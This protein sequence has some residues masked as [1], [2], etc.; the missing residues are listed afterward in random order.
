MRGKPKASPHV[1][2]D[3]EKR[4]KPIV[5]ID[6]AFLGPRDEKGQEL[7]DEEAEKKGYS[8]FLV[9]WDDEG[10]GLYAYAVEKKVPDEGLAKRVVYD[11]DTVE[12]RSQL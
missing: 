6:Y 2:G 1:K 10:K 9:M 11:L 3:V 5:A 4:S 12:P 7:T 8:P